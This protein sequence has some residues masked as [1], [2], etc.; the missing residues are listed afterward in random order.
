MWL[1]VA[2]PGTLIAV[3]ARRSPISPL[4][5]SPFCSL[6]VLA[7]PSRTALPMSL[8][9]L[10]RHMA[11]GSKLVPAGDGAGQLVATLYRSDDAEDADWAAAETDPAVVGDACCRP[12][13]GFG[14]P[15]FVHV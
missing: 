3:V 6:V 15:G 5:C 1:D 11:D 12:L 2:L 13:S 4:T 14:Q 9:G 7:R 8:L 10:V